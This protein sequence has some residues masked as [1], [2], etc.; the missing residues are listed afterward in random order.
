MIVSSYCKKNLSKKQ[1]CISFIATMSFSSYL[2]SSDLLLN[3]GNQRFFIFLDHIVSSSPL[4][5]ISVILEA[6]YFAPKKLG[7]ILVSF[8]QKA[9][10]STTCQILLKQGS[11]NSQVHKNTWKLHSWST[12][13]LKTSS[14]QDVH[15]LHCPLWIFSLTL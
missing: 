2:N 15:S 4:Y 5:L 3:M 14:L 8:W 9:F 10:V 12:P 7:S 6:S 13:L 1:T 11:V